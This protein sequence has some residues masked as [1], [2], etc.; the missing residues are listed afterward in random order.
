MLVHSVY[1]WF[2]ADADP[3][4]V[5]QF[6]GG[7]AQL[8]TIPDVRTAYFGKPEATPKRA[9]LDDS[10]SWALVLTFEDLAAHD[11]YQDHAIHH[12]FLNKFSSS[13]ERVRVYD[14]AHTA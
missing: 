8:T 7:L 10:Y 2:K 3:S 14:V 13:W 9:V 5:A 6:E 11:R 12:E 4:V 1:F